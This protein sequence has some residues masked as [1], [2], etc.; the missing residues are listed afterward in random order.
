MRRYAI[1]FFALLTV[2]L[3]GCG[4]SHDPDSSREEILSL[5]REGIRAH[6]DKDTGFFIRDISDDY[7][8]VGGGKIRHPSREDIEKNFRDY[9]TSTTFSRYEDL[10]EPV[11]GFSDDGSL[12]WSIVRV[13]VEG[14]R[15]VSPDSTR[16]LDFTCAWITLYRREGDRWIRLG[17]VSSFE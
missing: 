9:L 12:A 14:R 13:K 10:E 1:T 7:F 4:S 8:S 15:S 16:A 17:E 11:I 5:H 3:Q 2:V 6:F